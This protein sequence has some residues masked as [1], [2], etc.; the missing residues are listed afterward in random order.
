MVLKDK[1]Q[2]NS[3]CDHTSEEEDVSDAGMNGD[4]C[5]FHKEP[6]I[7]L[8]HVAKNSISPDPNKTIAIAQRKKP[9]SIS[10]LRQF[11]ANQVGM[12]ILCLLELS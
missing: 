12:F 2:V 7:F 4:K 9:Q 11:M 10:E 5:E 3:R 6:L 8:G 1:L